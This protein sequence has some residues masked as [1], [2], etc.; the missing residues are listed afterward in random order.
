M[1][2]R[3]KAKGTAAETAVVGYLRE[4]GWP[5]AERRTLAG[6]QDKGD[7]AGIPGLVVEVKDCQRLEFGPWLRE[8]Q[9]ERAN[10]GAEYGVVWAKRR[11]TRNPAD[12]YVLMDGDTF[13]RLLKDA[14]R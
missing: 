10:A 4:Q 13:T 6:N 3:A 5:H 8:A 14:E 2:N 9:V 12:W 1:T 7:L 11:G